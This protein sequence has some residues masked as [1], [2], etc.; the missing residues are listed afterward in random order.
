SMNLTT[1]IVIIGINIGCL[2]SPYFFALT[3]SVFGNSSA[4]F[5]IIVGGA[6]YFVMVVI[7]LI[8]LKV[9]KKLTV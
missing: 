1:S 8:T 7:E 3:A 6:L 4:G 5:A 9:D 2:I